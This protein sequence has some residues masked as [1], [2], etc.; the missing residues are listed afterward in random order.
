MTYAAAAANASLCR[1][2]ACKI[3]VKNHDNFTA[4][5]AGSLSNGERE[6]C[7][8]DTWC[9]CN[10]SD[11]SRDRAALQPCPGRCGARFSPLPRHAR[12]LSALPRI[13]HRPAAIAGTC[14][15]YPRTDAPPVAADGCGDCV[16]RACRSVAAPLGKPGH[17]L[18]LHLSAA[19]RR[20]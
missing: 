11:G 18:G 17:S 6:S 16:A 12:R 1:L 8:G 4:D 5:L 13:W 15:E 20:A 14:A 19:I 7:D 3:P 9:R 2:K 10:L